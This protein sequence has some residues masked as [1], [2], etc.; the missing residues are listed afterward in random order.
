M[1]NFQSIFPVLI[2]EF[3]KL[4]V[5]IEKCSS[6]EELFKSTLI[7]ISTY[8]FLIFEKFKEAATGTILQFNQNLVD[9]DKAIKFL[10]DNEV[11][12]SSCNLAG[13]RIRIQYASGDCGY[14]VESLCGCGPST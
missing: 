1:L 12:N 9:M 13:P 7:V 10:G 6:S 2:P 11:V 14:D 8:C 5:E 3:N 4:L